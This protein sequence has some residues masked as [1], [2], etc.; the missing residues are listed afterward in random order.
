MSIHIAMDGYNLIRQ[1]PNLSMIEHGGAEEGRKA[2]LRRLDSY[3]KLRHHPVTVVFGRADAEHSM[4]DM[5]RW[6]GI[7]V[8]FSRSGE[9]VDAA[10][11]RLVA[12]KRERIVVATSGRETTP[13]DS[14]HGAATI[15]SSEFENTMVSAAHPDMFPADF[16]DEQGGR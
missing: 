12:R 16:V 14:E 7:Q 13:F 3:K 1:S 11:K 4:E 6:E 9:S 15:A 5:V 8:L 10:I 2:L